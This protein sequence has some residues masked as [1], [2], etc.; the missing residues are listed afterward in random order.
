M[1]SQ[2]QA[3]QREAGFELSTNHGDG[4]PMELELRPKRGG[5][6]QE[7]FI[8]SQYGLERPLVRSDKFRTSGKT[9]YV[10][11][12]LKDFLFNSLEF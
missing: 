6:V 3:D 7:L 10:F 9:R 8:Y 11:L 5:Y 4:V 2:L 12:L 1:T